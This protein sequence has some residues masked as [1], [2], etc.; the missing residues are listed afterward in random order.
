[1]K[2]LSD[3]SLPHRKSLV[4]GP[5]R[6][7]I[8]KGLLHTYSIRTF[9]LAVPVQKAAGRIRAETGFVGVQG[10]RVRVF[11][12]FQ[13]LRKVRTETAVRGGHSPSSTS[14]CNI[15]GIRNVFTCCLQL[16]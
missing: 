14:L 4:I 11:E 6:K 13:L 16:L 2:K 9:A 8:N 7:G 12:A 3:V 1:M 5:T 15:I 10:D